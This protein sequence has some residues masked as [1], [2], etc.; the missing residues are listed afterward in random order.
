[1]KC[2]KKE[3]HNEY[4]GLAI[5]LLEQHDSVHLLASALKL[6]TG[7]DK[8][9]V[10]IELTPEDPIRAK[11]RRPDIRSNGRRP[12]GPYGTAGGARRNDRPY[13]GGDRGG[14]RR[15]GSRDGGRREGGY[16]ENRDYRG[17]SDNRQEGRSDRGGHTRS[18]NRS[19]EETLV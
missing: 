11:K 15:D 9:E 6:L 12:S 13:G 2:F 17:R 18:S 16:R 1:M 5:S 19:N 10:E 4:K 8:K 14:S 3:E 7:G